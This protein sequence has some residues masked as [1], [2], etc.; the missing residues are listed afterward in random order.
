MCLEAVLSH[1]C[2]IPLTNKT[3][4]TISSLKTEIGFAAMYM[5]ILCGCNA[6]R[7]L[8]IGPTTL[9][10]AFVVFYVQTANILWLLSLHV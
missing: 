9:V 10:E 6:Y 7:L 8:T 5:Q 3:I 2:Y 4:I 1:S